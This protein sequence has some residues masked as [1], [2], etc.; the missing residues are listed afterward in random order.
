MNSIT[1]SQRKIK[2]HKKL[3]RYI[4]YY[5]YKKIIE[6]TNYKNGTDFEKIA[7]ELGI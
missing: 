6:S 1:A 5:L 4:E 7:N 2:S 3:I